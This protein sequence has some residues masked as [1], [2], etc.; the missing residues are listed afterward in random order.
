MESGWLVTV[1]G[2]P[3]RLERANLAFRAVAVPE[4]RHRVEFVYGPAVVGPVTWISAVSL[5]LLAG[6]AW[7]VRPRSFGGVAAPA[8][9][10]P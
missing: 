6:G 3:A 7:I 2:R 1:D 4:G 10:A 8:A 9:S 5:A